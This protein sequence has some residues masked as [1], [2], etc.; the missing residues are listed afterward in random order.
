MAI[1]GAS[2]DPAKWGYALSRNALKGRDR[3][4]IFLVNRNGPEILGEQSYRSLEQLPESPE[5]VVITVRATAF[6][7][8]I[9]DAVRA[10]AHA[11]VAITAGLGERGDDGRA[12]QDEAVAR[13]REAG[14]ILVGPNC[15]GI[16]DSTMNLDLTW[17]DFGPGPVA[18]ISQ[19]GN[20][21]LELAQH[22]HHAAVGFTRFVSLGN[23]A[24]LDAA[25]CLEEVISHEPT[26][27]I[28]VYIEDFGD[29]R[30]FAAAAAQATRAGKPV[31]LL[32][33]GAT[34]AS[35]RTAHSHTGAL[36]SDS[37]AVD[38]ACH[39]SGMYRVETPQQMIDL[40]QVLLMPDPLPGPR[41][42]IVGDGGGH[43]ALAA[44]RLIA[45][46]LRVEPVS[47]SVAARLAEGLPATAATS[48]P[49]DIAGG[50]EEDVWNFERAARGLMASGEVDAVLVTGYFGGYS[51]QIEPYAKLEI[52]VAEAMA[53][54]SRRTRR[55]LI[56]QTMYPRS[57]TSMALRR[58][59]VPVFADIEAA[60]TA[61]GRLQFPPAWGNLP[62]PLR[63]RVGVGGR[64]IPTDYFSLRHLLEEA[65]I[66]FV[67][68]RPAKT[69]QEVIAAANILGYPVVLKALGQTHKSD[70][71]G[72]RLA[73]ANEAA[74]LEAFRDMHGRLHPPLFSVEREAPIELG[75]EL[76]IGIKHDHS[77]GPIA[78]V[79]LGGL[80]A[81]VFR[82]A[83]VALAPIALDQ[84][85][86]LITSLRGAQLL[87]GWRS[88]PP[89]DIHLAADALSK[90][91]ALAED[92]PA[93]Q[94]IEI[95]PLLVLEHGVLALDA[96]A[97]LA[98]DGRL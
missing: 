95:N 6:A 48:N 40:A 98:E 22:A 96:R 81:E 87:I 33:V 67:E 17:D 13:C 39:A 55:P 9:D 29:G 31:I 44:D 82:D 49:V 42:G 24:D 5:L 16:A 72:V 20:I 50:G 78:L 80:H 12:L 79:G 19:S 25:E 83:S 59:G 86:A 37:L 90:L 94:E 74:L 77:F 15:L 18:L 58:Q 91:S 52:E 41:F 60:G 62:P 70:A 26:R 88:R 45:H 47:A 85:V 34:D 63:G 21:G 23:Q 61:L 38:A 51:E 92:W 93:I 73:I 27:V 46:G 8:A 10:G 56:I 71:G 66:P 64:K 43:V 14:I 32:T 36:V 65:G 1:L 3:R 2:A 89:L 35:T 75:V 53:A 97:I 4:K 76:L 7:S 54:D 28:A 84:A 57:P 69:E 30:R 11:I 68:A